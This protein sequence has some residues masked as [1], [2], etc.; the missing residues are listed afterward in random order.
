MENRQHPRVCIPL[1][2]ELTHA[3]I[4]TR[5]AT[6]R[7]LSDGG[8]FI[9]LDDHPLQ[10]GAQLKIRR[11]RTAVDDSQSNPTVDVQVVRI[12]DEGVALR[13]KNKTAHHL[14]SSVERLR[15]ELS[16]GQDYFQAYEAILCQHLDKGMLFVQQHG[17]WTLPG[18]YLKVDVPIADGRRAYLKTELGIS[19]FT[20]AQVH[21][22][23]SFHSE[24]IPEAST[25][26]IVQG[27]TLAQP[28][29]QLPADSSI[30]ETRWIAKHK[31]LADLTV[32]HGWIRDVATRHLRQM[33]EA[34]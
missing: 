19:E 32:S 17:K 29:P 20:A 27:I 28:Q 1:V 18:H 16:I 8:L 2:V 26:C 4:G 25:L 21:G 12:E 10:Q 11:Q 5:E 3:T 14:W 15:S 7:D 6:A 23:H 33:E 24:F 34:S 31:D 13:F 9:Y 30:K 22:V